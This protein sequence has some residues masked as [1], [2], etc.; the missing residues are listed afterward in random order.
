MLTS[1][2]IHKNTF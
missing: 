2:R 1:H